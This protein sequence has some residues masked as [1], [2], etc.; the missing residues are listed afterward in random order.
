M[1]LSETT[2]FAKI[3]R[4][5]RNNPENCLG[6]STVD[7]T[8]GPKYLSRTNAKSKRMKGR[9]LRLAWAIYATTETAWSTTLF[10]Q[11]RSL[12]DLELTAGS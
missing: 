6:V 2:C 7:V 12:P 1:Y 10:I 4:E 11:D 8:G 3:Y 9:A 5:K